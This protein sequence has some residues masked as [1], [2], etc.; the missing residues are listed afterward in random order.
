MVAFERRGWRIEVIN[1]FVAK[2][3]DGEIKKITKGNFLKLF[4]WRCSIFKIAF[5]LLDTKSGNLAFR[6]INNALRSSSQH[7][8]EKK[9]FG[10]LKNEFILKN[11]FYKSWAFDKKL[12]N[13]TLLLNLEYEVKGLRIKLQNEAFYS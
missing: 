4:P 11:D 3:K 1:Q 5:D 10:R 7:R 9:D 8:Q 2:E 13:M 6:Q 12:C